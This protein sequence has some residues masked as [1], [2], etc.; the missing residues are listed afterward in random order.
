MC[1][2]MLPCPPGR[3]QERS[4]RSGL[5]TIFLVVETRVDAPLMPLK[6]FRLRTVAVA[7]AV[8]MLLGG[9]FFAFI[10]L[11]GEGSTTGAALTGGFQWAFWVC[12]AIAFLALPA[13]ATL[14]RRRVTAAGV[15]R[16]VPVLEADRVG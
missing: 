11:I 9:S 5:P 1:D 15:E 12:A 10:S 13:T 2:L 4:P 3:L 16:A 7:N 6:I 14:A 8:G